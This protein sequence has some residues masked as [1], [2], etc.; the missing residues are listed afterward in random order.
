MKL[1]PILMLAGGVAVGAAVLLSDDEL[2]KEKQRMTPQ[3]RALFDRLMTTERNAA[4]VGAG[5]ADFNAK[6]FPRAARALAGRA[7]T[8]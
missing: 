5:A 8:M 6:G 3:R 1:L 7:K 2:A 4:Q